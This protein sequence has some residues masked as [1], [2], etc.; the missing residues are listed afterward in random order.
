MEAYGIC[1]NYHGCSQF[2]RR[3][4]AQEGDTCSECGHALLHE[5]GLTWEDARRAQEVK[6]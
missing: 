2:E 1:V 5:S 4:P 6:V 3:V